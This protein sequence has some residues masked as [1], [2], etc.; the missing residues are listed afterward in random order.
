M[1]L[2]RIPATLAVMSLA[3]GQ[4]GCCC[5]CKKKEPVYVP[6]APVCATP[7]YT[8]PCPPGATTSYMPMQSTMPTYPAAG[9]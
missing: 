6:P 9:Y 8:N 4:A 7:V 3:V 2:T 1:K 5:L